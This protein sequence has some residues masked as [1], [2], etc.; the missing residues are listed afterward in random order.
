DS[1]RGNPILLTFHKGLGCLHCTEQLRELAKHEKEIR[2]LG[3]SIIAVG[4]E[5]ITPQESRFYAE[6]H[7]VSFPLLGD[8]AHKVYAQMSCL[9]KSGEPSHGVFLLDRD[10]VIQWYSLTEDAV[11]D[12]EMLIREARRVIDKSKEAKSINPTRTGGP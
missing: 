10:H 2:A 5:V 4:P 12:I 8:S 6:K 3:M 7:G 11:T 9:N 1:F